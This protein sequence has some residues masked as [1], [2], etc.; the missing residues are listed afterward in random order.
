[1]KPLKRNHLLIPSRYEDF[2][3]QKALN[4][5]QKRNKMRL[6]NHNFTILAN[7]CV[8]AQIYRDWG[9]RFDTPL[10]GLYIS[11]ED[12]VLLLSDLHYWL[13]Q[14]ITEYK[15]NLNFP[16]GLLGEKIKIFFRS[17]KTFDEAITKW[18]RRLER[19]HWDK[20]FVFLNL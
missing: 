16:I 19:I 5:Y 6:N 9:M 14:P 11:P 2:F 8:G 18:N 7:S 12:F 10:V 3:E 13:Y 1:M 17:D 20:L 4:R 15:S